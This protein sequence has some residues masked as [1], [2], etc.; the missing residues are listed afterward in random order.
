MDAVDAEPARDCLEGASAAERDGAVLDDDGPITRDVVTLKSRPHKGEQFGLI[1]DF[2]S[3]DP[4]DGPRMWRAMH[5]LSEAA[6]E[7]LMQEL[8][9]FGLVTAVFG[10]RPWT[11]GAAFRPGPAMRSERGRDDAPLNTTEI[12]DLGTLTLTPGLF[13]LFLSARWSLSKSQQCCFDAFVTTPCAASRSP[14]AAPRTPVRGSP[15]RGGHGIRSSGDGDY[16]THDQNFRD[17]LTRGSRSVCSHMN[18]ISTRLRLCETRMHRDNES[19]ER[20]RVDLIAFD[21]GNESQQFDDN[22]LLRFT[23]LAG[24]GTRLTRASF[25]PSG[26]APRSPVHGGHGIRSSGD[27]DY[28]AHDQN[29]RDPLTRGVPQRAARAILSDGVVADP[30]LDVV[31]P[32]LDLPCCGTGML[33]R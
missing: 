32:R 14:C 15:F 21:D 11:D 1:L 12:L 17:P 7:A 22:A 5:A 19:C 25:G 13:R 20:P 28:F 29:F 2:L 18:T 26:A 4:P 16:F 3:G 31:V 10:G 27:G 6:Q 9:Y 24:S 30:A 8:D 33:L 23:A